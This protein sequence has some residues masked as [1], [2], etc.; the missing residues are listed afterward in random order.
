MKIWTV[1]FI[2]KE[3]KRRVQ[4]MTDYV[5]KSK[6]KAETFANVELTQMEGANIIGTHIQEHELV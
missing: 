6:A 2:H 4:F 5:F 3:G 1:T